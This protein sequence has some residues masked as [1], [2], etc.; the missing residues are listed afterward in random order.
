MS[1]IIIEICFRNFI[2]KYFFYMSQ[3]ICCLLKK[4][5]EATSKK[6]A[7]FIYKMCSEIFK[8][9]TDFK[10]NKP[11][12][13]ITHNQYCDICRCPY[14]TNN[15]VLKCMFFMHFLNYFLP[16]LAD[17]S[18]RLFIPSQILYKSLVFDS[19][20]FGVTNNISI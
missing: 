2:Q 14:F 17:L 7:A 5:A 6:T 11:K 15:C 10:G 16:Y 20:A 3:P 12:N 9:F 4:H 8:L 18:C 13:I 19:A 1:L